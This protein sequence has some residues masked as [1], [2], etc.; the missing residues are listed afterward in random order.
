MQNKFAFASTG[1]HIGPMARPPQITRRN[2]A[3]LM[4]AGPIS[5][6]EMA[7]RLGVNR[8]TIVRGL[9]SL[10]DEVISMGATRRT[11]YAL[12]RSLGNAGNRW[13]VYTID[14]AGKPQL[15]AELEA[16]HERLW[17]IRWQSAAPAWAS[18]FSD[19]EG[20][21]DGFP[22]FL[23]GMRPQGYLGREITRLLSRTLS[24]PQDPRAWSDEH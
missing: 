18:F 22:F 16:L 11:R 3:P 15:W 12:R 17:R 10:G 8:T 21:W 4:L 7:A 2:L 5:A 13:P 20:L 9:S 6:T 14:Q 1:Q 23:G 24:L 19:P